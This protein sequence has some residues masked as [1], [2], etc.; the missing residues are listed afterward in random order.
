MQICE[1]KPPKLSRNVLAQSICTHYSCFENMGR[2][3][4]LKKIRSKIWTWKKQVAKNKVIV[5]QKEKKQPGLFSF[6]ITMT[7]LF[8]THIFTGSQTDPCFQNKNSGC[9]LTGRVIYHSWNFNFSCG[10]MFWIRKRKWYFTLNHRKH[11]PALWFRRSMFG[12]RLFG[13]LQSK[14]QFNNRKCRIL[15]SMRNKNTF[16]FRKSFTIS[17]RKMSSKELKLLPCPS[18]SPKL[19]LTVQI[20]LVK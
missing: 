3:V 19:F 14:N 12:G 17:A 5:I 15:Q 7:L 2:F 10:S 6:W 11:L 4:T 1:V 20:N 16:S 18:M 8:A 13:I 9:R